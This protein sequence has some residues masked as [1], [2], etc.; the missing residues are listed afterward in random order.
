M[1]ILIF[2][3]YLLRGTGSNV[4][5]ANLARAL[6]EL[7]HEVHL[8]CQDG[9]AAALPWVDRVG[10]WRG[11]EMIVE[12][13]VGGDGSVTVYTPDIGGLLPVYVHDRYEGFEVKVFPDLS[14]AELDRYLRSNVAAVAE[15]AERAG[16]IDAA[17][18]NHV[19]MGPAILARADLE[20][21][22]AAKVHGS[23]L[24][25][26]VRPHPQR[27]LGYAR[28]GMA[29]AAAV[30]V[31][32]RHTAESL[33][34]TI[35]DPSLPAKTRLGPPGVETEAFRS[36]DPEQAAAE[37]ASLAGRLERAVTDDDAFGR[38][39]R[40][41]AVAIRE[42]A[43]RTPRV[44]YVGKLIPQKGVELLLEAWPAV[45]AANPGA[46][47]LIAGFGEHE[48]ELRRL[49]AD[50]VSFS[51]RLEHD[52]VAVA[53]GAAD[54][55]VVPSVFPEAF[56]MVAAE[57]AASGALPVCADHSGLHEVASRLAQAL[58]AEIA[59]LVAF[60]LG[61][62]A[63]AQIAERLNRWLALP[64]AERNSAGRAL[65]G[66]VRE[67]WSWEGVARGVIA[68]SAGDVSELPEVPGPDQ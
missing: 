57:G 13:E 25:Y 4:Y 62:D 24:E 60:P 41:A 3:G 30:L 66:V 35:A 19:V 37:L 26:T 31:G 10:R 33:W 64:A 68:A 20:H 34:R 9:D 29:A 42:F 22:F 59:D 14:E 67:R 36:R 63:P 54:A 45:A 16:G 53:M 17:L 39:P 44:L 40:Q 21:G 48:Q 1:R 23:A 2:H 7:G 61:D 32:S 43:S 8:L 11:G 38:D 58:P 49:A 51:G 52:E 65:A 15:V 47:L 46:S 28:E 27:F 50:G 56:G 18:A 5:N 12:G 6:R 55:L